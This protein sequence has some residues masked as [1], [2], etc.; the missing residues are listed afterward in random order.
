MASY[1]VTGGAGFI[2]S[3]LTE[4]LVRRGHTVR[5]VDNLVTGS[6][7]N[8]AHVP[9]VAFLEGDLADPAVAERAAAGMD[10]VLHQAAIPSV[11][12]SVSDPVTSN[13]ANIDASLSILVAAR[14]AGVKRLVYAGSSA[15]Y[16]DTPTLPKREDMPTNPLSPYA[17]QKLVAELYCQMFTRL[18]GLETVTIRYFNVFGPRQD[19]GSPYSGVISLFATALLGRRRPVIYGDG[20]QTRDFT[21][22][23]NVVDGVLRACAAPKAIGEVINVATGGRTSLNE[24]LRTMNRVVGTDLEA[25]YHEPRAGDVRDSQADITKARAL[26]EYTPI[27]GLEDGLTKTLEWCRGETAAGGS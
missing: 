10:Y 2:G 5:V 13:R 1:L 20:E 12:R 16:G 11:P 24:L 27:V 15:A 22:V 14:D 8:L 21:Y 17:L 3:H 6:R 4:E 25:I 23:A 26:L 18:Y 9:G 7:R 19:P